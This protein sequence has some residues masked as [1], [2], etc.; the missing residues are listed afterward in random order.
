MNRQF[1]LRVEVSYWRFHL[2][3]QSYDLPNDVAAVAEFIFRLCRYRHRRTPT[4]SIALANSA[5]LSYSFR[6][7]NFILSNHISNRFIPVYGKV[8]LAPGESV[9]W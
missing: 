4:D 6:R 9:R 7:C 2:G 8:A 5:F 1:Q 3:K